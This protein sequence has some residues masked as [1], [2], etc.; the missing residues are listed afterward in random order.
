MTMALTTGFLGSWAISWW[1]LVAI[2]A[3]SITWSI[4]R[5]R[6]RDKRAVL[7]AVLAFALV[8]QFV[9]I[10]MAAERH[11]KRKLLTGF[12]QDLRRS[13]S[14]DAVAGSPQA[15]WIANVKGTKPFHVIVGGVE[16]LGRRQSNQSP[17]S[18]L[19]ELLGSAPSLVPGSTGDLGGIVGCAD[20]PSKVQSVQSV[21]VDGRAF[22]IRCGWADFG[23]VGLLLPAAGQSRTQ[24]SNVAHG[25]R[26]QVQFRQDGYS[27]FKNAGQSALFIA[28]AAFG[29]LASLAL[30]ELA[31]AVV[32]W[33]VGTKVNVICIGAG[34]TLIER[35]I[36][37]T[38][39]IVRVKPLGGFVQT[40]A[41][42]SAGYRWKATAVWAAGPGANALLAL[43]STSVFG[44][45]SLLTLC[46]IAMCTFNLLPFSKFI[47]EIGQRIGTDGYQ[48][49]Q[50]ATGRRSFV[51]V[52][53][54]EATAGSMPTA[55]DKQPGWLRFAML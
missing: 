53:E 17:A 52:E 47:P 13:S 48:I 4:R 26:A 35:T 32:A 10:T 39:F 44:F 15:L 54:T 3:M 19:E 5:G 34:R 41:T 8:S 18:A 42:T 40:Q 2:I 55:T 7:G 12:R 37:N 28:L 11:Q 16:V 29:I 25:V 46:N 22:P 9:P 43:L 38:V 6:Q 21:P 51:E 36:G 23:T 31:H 20:T 1:P 27:P 24:L 50:F 45:E 49:L 33:S 30:H 14:A